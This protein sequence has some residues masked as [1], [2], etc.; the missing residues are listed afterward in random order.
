MFLFFFTLNM[1]YD[2]LFVFTEGPIGYTFMGA[3]VATIILFT[4]LCLAEPGFVDQ[5]KGNIY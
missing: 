3:T 5:K 4:Y 2:A 1:L